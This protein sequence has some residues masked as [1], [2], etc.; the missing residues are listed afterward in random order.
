MAVARPSLARRLAVTGRAWM[1]GAAERRRLT[2]DGRHG[3]LVRGSVRR[4]QVRLEGR[5]RAKIRKGAIRG[6]ALAVAFAVVFGAGVFAPARAATWLE[7]NFW[8]SGPNYSRD[9]PSCEYHAALDRIISDFRTKEFRFW[10]SELRILGFEDIHELATMPWAAQSIPRRFC[11][12]TAVVN[13]QTKRPIYYS[14]AEDT[15]MIGIDWGVSFCVVGLD[16]NL[17]YGPNCRG[18]QP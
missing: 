12:G 2:G 3:T 5:L 8:M 17:A 16:R 11:G 10:N 14:I 1:V 9:L 6:A 13:D 15:G 18:A 4:G 7:K